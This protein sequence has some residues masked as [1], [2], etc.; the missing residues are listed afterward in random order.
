MTGEWQ[1]LQPL[2][3][4]R[5]IPETPS[6]HMEEMLEKHLLC[7]FVHIAPTCQGFS[8][9]PALKNSKKHLG[10][11]NCALLDDNS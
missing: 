11:Q 7:C 10:C 6:E 1:N 8:S 9:I 5:H 2:S 3:Q 4:D